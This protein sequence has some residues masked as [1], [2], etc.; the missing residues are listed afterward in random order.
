[1]KM[2]LE[3]PTKL[4]LPADNDAVQKFLTFTDRSVEY[5]IKKVRM[6]YRWKNSS[7]EGHLAR[8]EALKAQMRVCMLFHDD[9]GRPW[10]YAGLWRD[11]QQVFHWELESQITFPEAKLVPWAHP[12]EHKARYYQEESIVELLKARHGAIALPT[13]SGKSLVIIELCKRLGLKTII[14][15]PSASITDQLY[16]EFLVRFGAKRVGKY[17]DGS[18]K[19]DKLFT[20]CTGQALTRIE[21]GSEAW[22]DLSKSAVFIADECFPS[23][24]KIV[25]SLGS[26]RISSVFNDFQKG[27]STDVLSFN[28]TEKRFEFRKVTNAW[29]RDQK[30]NL[31]SVS[32]GNRH[33]ACTEDHKI[34]TVAGWVAAKDLAPGHLII[35]SRDI[36]A[37]KNSSATVFNADQHQMVYGSYLGD[38][39]IS[40]HN[41]GRCRLR[42]IHGLDQ[43]G[44]LEWKNSIFGNN[45]LEFLEK[46]GFSQKPAWRFTTKLFDSDIPFSSPKGAG[47]A[48]VAKKI[49]LRGLAIWY[50]D[51][52]N[53][54]KSSATCAIR[55]HTESLPLEGQD[56]L[57]SAIERLTGARA[58]VQPSKKQGKIYYYLS[59][60]GR[61]G[62]KAFLEKIAPYSSGT[63][64]YKF[65]E[66]LH[67]SVGA[68]SWDA[69]AL[70]YGTNLVTGV[71]R[72]GPMDLLSATQ[73]QNFNRNR[74]LTQLYDLEVEGNHNF[75]VGD[76]TGI[77]AHNC[78]VTP[79][80]TFDK[81]CN[82]V[83]ASA[84][85]RFFVSATQIRNDG[86][87]MVLNGITGPIVYEKPFRELVQQ[88]FLAEPV[89]KI[90]HVPCGQGT[91]SDD[92]MVETRN[93][94]YLNP[95]VNSLTGQIV[96]KAVKL[97]NRQVV[98]LVDEFKQFMV[99]RNYLNVPYEFVHGTPSA[100]EKKNLPEE[101]WKC[102]IEA[103]VGR[104]NAGECRV[105]I[106][107]S[108]ISTGVDL[109][110]VG[111]L[112]YLQGGTSEVQ[113]KQG[114][115]RATRVVP[116]KKDFWLVDFKVMGSP[117]MERHLDT[118]EEFYREFTDKVDHYG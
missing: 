111:C 16:R 56:V 29:R 115:G 116:G 3:N 55:L 35:G 22:E 94:L 32:M 54:Q 104:F 6:N 1:M 45:Q 30:N 101:Y 10:T 78:H 31:I 47:L 9:E 2:I 117:K 26:R 48:E 11:L 97:A 58:H 67:A 77:V 60:N 17:G 21:Q 113:V 5:Q 79:A 100:E 90:F 102:D 95:H 20:V 87:Q 23:D 110:P 96:E 80:A 85:Y 36:K 84:P 114:L 64:L 93:Q 39:G 25:T 106:G 82:G 7:P 76:R 38:G 109:K 8:L 51:D 92:A 52:G 37:K 74:H 46:N 65:P 18:K 69:A 89:V 42:I 28:E 13:G 61:S 107:T 75:T 34:L 59:I 24:T 108:A 99:L 14:M 73:K 49:D 81:V 105:L 83:A 86:S 41:S 103:S 112:V 4:I 66:D 118:R 91:C 33:F 72:V 70:G 57:I 88:G 27:I 43:K 68:Y 53:L 62:A 50:M 12:P 63:M 40:K 19:T 98:I 44:Y 71:K 15:T